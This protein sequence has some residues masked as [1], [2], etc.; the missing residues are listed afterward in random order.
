MRSEQSV[1]IVL[2]VDV[3]KEEFCDRNYIVVKKAEWRKSSAQFFA[4]NNVVIKPLVE[5][6]VKEV[7]DTPEPLLDKG[8]GSYRVKVYFVQYFFEAIYEEF[9]IKQNREA[10]PVVGTTPLIRRKDFRI[11]SIITERVGE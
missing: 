2:D 3:C 9:I 5:Q 7:I 6:V 1:F 10:I 11:S 4:N 8:V